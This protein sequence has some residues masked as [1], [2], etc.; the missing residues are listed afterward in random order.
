MEDLQKQNNNCSPLEQEL[1]TKAGELAAKRMMREQQMVDIK[2]GQI[3]EGVTSKAAEV[4]E[5]M[6]NKNP[7]MQA[8]RQ[9]VVKEVMRSAEG[10]LWCREYEQRA[11]AE[12]RMVVY[13][14]SHWQPVLPQQWK[15]F[16]SKCAT[17]CGLNE[18]MTM[19]H[20]FMNALCEGVAYN[21]AEHRQ[22][23]TPPG[24]AWLNMKNGTLIVS[25]DGSVRLRP[26]RKE[27]LFTY[28][29]D[30]CY[31]SEARCDQWHIFLDRVLAEPEAQKV[32]AEFIGYCL[33]PSHSP[34]KLL[35][36]YGEGLNGKSVTL[37]VIEALL[38]TVNVSYLSL[39]D[40][41]NDEVKRAGIVGK[42]LNISHES[43][44]DVN[45]NVLKQLTSGEPVL[46]KNLYHD[47]RETS[48]YGKFAAAFNQLPR[49]ENSF[50]FFRRLIILPYLV[51][52]PAEEI[53][54]QLAQKLKA[55]LPGI[56][57]WVLSAL[58]GLMPRG[59]FTRS[60][61]CEK[62]LDHYRL[63]SDSVRLFLN[64]KCEPQEYSTPAADINKAYREFCFSSSL[65]PLGRTRFY[66]RLESLTH[67]RVDY[68]GNLYFKLRLLDS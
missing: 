33:M 68:Q 32:L 39:S 61:S 27:D 3:A 49:A 63:M 58:P 10:R 25:S 42:L 20:S 1:A 35:L 30:Y 37:E 46:V 5:L 13:T 18:S 54:R 11:K 34:E 17:R 64:E 57:N 51:T 4:M 60:E 8:V 40:L 66:E 23:L 2:L 31:D 43:G 15:D 65:K 53:D 41:T 22:R 48:D 38:G 14:G 62:A 6:S 19:N 52:I 47:P 36:L 16:V 28:T 45:P 12:Q 29:L 50:G 44:R 7:S 56:L 9:V 55:E 24:E 59:D 67:S 21:L 26:H